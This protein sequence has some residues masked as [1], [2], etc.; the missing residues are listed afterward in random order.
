P[1]DERVVQAPDRGL[2]HVWPSGGGTEQLFS[3]TVL[4]SRPVVQVSLGEHHGVL[5]AQGGQVFSFGELSWRGLSVPVSAPVLE[6][7]L[8]GRTVVYVAA[9]GFHCGVISEQ[10]SVYMW[11]EN[12]A[13]QCGQTERAFVTN[14]TAVGLGEWM[15]AWPRH[16]YLPCVETSEGM[17]K[18]EYT[19]ASDVFDF[20]NQICIVACGAYHSLALV[21]SLPAQHFST[22]ST[23]KMRE[24]DR[25]LQCP[26]PDR[27]ELVTAEDAHYCP[28]GVEL[29]EVTRSEVNTSLLLPEDM[30]PDSGSIQLECHLAAAPSPDPLL[31]CFCM[32]RLQPL[33]IK[34]LTGQE[35]IKV[36]AGSHHSLALT[37][38]CQLSDGLRVWDVSAGQSHSLLLADGDCV[39]PVLLYCG[40]QSE[41]PS[42][43]SEE[44][45]NRG[46]SQTSHNRAE[47]YSVR[48]TLL[49]FCIEM[50]Y[51]SSVYGSGRM[52]A[53][54][55][56]RNM[57]GFIAAI[58][59]LAS[60]E[61]RF[62]CW[63][64]DVRKV[65]LTPLRTKGENRLDALIGDQTCL[66]RTGFYAFTRDFSP[67][68]STCQMLG[69]L[70]THLFFALCESFIHLSKL[71][72][73]HAASLSYFLQN[74]QSR[75]VTSFPLLTHSER[76]L[77]TYRK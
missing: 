63:M 2:L 56:D 33:C 1:A 24:R 48:P 16:Q 23:P 50:N 25:S 73:R 11:G 75:D 66:R 10:G 64:S 22:Q 38:Q 71:V 61:R 67:T 39:Q 20:I 77:E 27:E 26:V 52:C 34:S 5:L 3:E 9:G 65:L 54:L 40:Q 37:A 15:P 72:S 13:G 18:A 19:S 74:A 49:P 12:T 53:A 51:I 17:F 55:T 31:L 42:A 14:I 69:E 4:L 62:C 30:F 60:R 43:L 57:M 32:S 76:F 59:E 29:S 68:E 6:A 70:C 28:L 44:V 58:H 47:S 21:C 46:S 36:A 35:V 45:Q 41:P 7:S 8:L